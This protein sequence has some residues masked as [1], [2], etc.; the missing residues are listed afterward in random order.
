MF[1][2]VYNLKSSDSRMLFCSNSY[3]YCSTQ[4]PFWFSVL[5]HNWWT[6]FHFL[7]CEY[8]NYLQHTT[9]CLQNLIA[10][11]SYKHVSLAWEKSSNLTTINISLAYIKY[12]KWPRIPLVCHI[13]SLNFLKR[14]SL[15]SRKTFNLIDKYGGWNGPQAKKV[16]LPVRLSC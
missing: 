15:N 2:Q 16:T 1:L 6:L 5:K 13:I 4:G 12:S 11:Q 3:N 14:N 9:A 7:P 8:L 10:F